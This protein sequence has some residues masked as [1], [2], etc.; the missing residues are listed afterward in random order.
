[1]EL[2]TDMI[3]ISDIKQ[4]KQKHQTSER[5]KIDLFSNS[6]NHKEGDKLKTSVKQL[7]KT[8]FVSC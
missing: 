5:S 4:I 8:Y 1:M 6:T 2:I 3:E 7:H